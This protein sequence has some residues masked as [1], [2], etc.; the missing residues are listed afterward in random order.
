MDN[1]LKIYKTLDDQ[2]NTIKLFIFLILI[3]A[4]LEILGV[5]LVVPVLTLIL[6]SS[7]VITINLEFL[8]LQNLRFNKENLLLGTVIFIFF[9]YSIKSFF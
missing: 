4:I 1:I 5:A 8:S 3:S 6:S 2:K 9:F 7:E